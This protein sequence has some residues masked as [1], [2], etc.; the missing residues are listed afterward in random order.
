MT[1]CSAL[2]KLYVVKVSVYCSGRTDPVFISYRLY[3]EICS[4]AR[5]NLAYVLLLPAAASMLYSMYL[6]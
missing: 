2:Y 5:S 4:I 6:I 3:T 1:H